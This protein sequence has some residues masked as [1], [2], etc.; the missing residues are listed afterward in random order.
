M[1][2]PIYFALSLL[3]LLSVIGLG[4]G[5]L[6]A[7]STELYDLVLQGGRVMDPETGLDAVRH[8]GIRGDRVV[9]ISEK[10]LKGREVVDV[11]KFVVAP[12]FIDLHAH[13][14]TNKAN[15]FQV[16]DGVTTALELEGGKGF[17]RQWL[18]S[19]AG[20]ALIN[21]GASVSQATVR[22][23]AMKKYAQQVSQAQ[24]IVA[25]QGIDSGRLED[26]FGAASGARYEAL[27]T[28]EMESMVQGLSV[29]L[30]EGGLGIGVPLGYYPGA[31]QEE[32][33]RVYALAARTQAPIFTHV[34][35]P[36]ITAIQE[37]IANA[38]VTGAPLHIVHINSMALG[39]IGV[40]LEMVAA[41]QRHGLD[42]TTE[43]Y[44]Y[45]AAS[46][47]LQSALFDPGWQERLGISYKDLQWEA[48]GERLTEESFKKYREQ[49][50]TVI[51]HMMKSEWIDMG[52]GASFT[53][54]ASDGMPYA[55]GAH[56]R[57]AGTFA[58]VLGRYV[59]EKKTLTL[60]GALGKMTIMPTKR[61]EGIAPVM[62]LK[63]RIQV[64]CDADIT[65][66][67]PD[68]I[69][70]TATFEKGV[71]FS[72]GVYH[73]LVNGTFVVKN[74]RSVSGVYPGRPVL[75]RYRR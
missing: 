9:E 71:S 17:L 75:G 33:F 55:P 60:M 28:K 3:A 43:L 13:G 73:V 45:T 68:V 22:W 50:G 20:K 15:E 42:I 1:V 2:Q 25:E 11:S 34:R 66:F 61:L 38:A 23:M 8:V 7:E 31:T 4:R 58:R 14:Q 59:R 62:R 49:G 30:E 5:P 53:M 12:G 19:R 56:P 65:V 27:N 36:S 63:G 70:D 69:L 51:M 64:G 26:V 35:D 48:T 40:A 6:Q 24:R 47:S 74:G 10:P 54:I 41:A 57:S 32:I 37:A 72:E 52:V 67:D 21:F 29:G 46:T 16:H 39:H 18:D 44:P